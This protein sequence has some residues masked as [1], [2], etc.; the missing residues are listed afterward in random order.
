MATATLLPDTLQPAVTTKQCRFCGADLRRTF[1]DLG[2]SPLCETCPA[3]ADLNRGEIYYP[4]TYTS[5]NNAS[6]CSWNNTRVPRISSA[7]TLI[8]L[9]TLIP[10][11]STAENYCDRM[12]TRLGLNEQ[13]F[14]VEVASNDG[15]LL[16]YFV[17]RNVRVLGIEPA[18]NV[19]KVASRKGSPYPDKVLRRATSR[20]TGGRGHL[21]RPGC[22]A[23]T[24]LPRS[25]T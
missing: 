3:P 6:W 10:G 18:A 16:Q 4:L 2:M 17:E 1:V 19:A 13:S 9:P 8:S 22:S 23:I 12:I 11:S 21:R 5:A 14:V 7:T 20:R 25:R 24:C 15:Y